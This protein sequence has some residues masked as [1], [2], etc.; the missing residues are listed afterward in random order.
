MNLIQLKAS[1]RQKEISKQEFID[2][3]YKKH[4][5][6][7]L[8]CSLISNTDI[9]SIE[10][11]DDEIRFTSRTD[12]L[13][14]SCSLADKRSAPFEI[15]NFGQY[16]STDAE[17]IYKL[18]NNG[19][20]V[21]DIGANIGW[22][23]MS[24]AKRNPASHIHAFEPVPSTFGML[25]TNVMLNK[26]SNIRCYNMGFSEVNKTSDFFVSNATSVSS[27]AKNISGSD[28]KKVS[29]QLKK[30]DDFLLGSGLVIDFIK[31]DVEGA[32][33][34]VFEGGIEVLR[35]QQPIVFSEMLRKWTA[36]YGYSPNDIIEL[37]ASLGYR[38][39]FIDKSG[40]LKSIERIT[41]DTIQTNF[42]FLH[43]KKHISQIENLVK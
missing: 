26:V 17:M 22:Y 2:R 23:S 16:E 30:M 39:Y 9:K 24:L 41:E 29:C 43:K 8:Y 12:E 33:L 32:E 27:S 19:D 25:E 3:M 28:V 18:V 31:C 10:I 40:Y 34:F 1:F 42:T 37:F 15:L 13:I 14:F 38:T 11:L 35:T 20:V 6:L 7:F 36:V 21:L 4:Q 5:D